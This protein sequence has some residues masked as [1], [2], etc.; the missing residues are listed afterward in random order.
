MEINY[1]VVIRTIGKA[2][3]KYQ[4]LLDSIDALEPKPQ[5]VIVVLPEGYE[6]PKEQLGYERFCFSKKGMIYQRVY[7]LEQCKTPYA[8]FCDD[9]V[10]FPPDF[11]QKLFRPIGQGL[12]GLSAGPLLSFLPDKGF[13]S[14][15]SAILGSAVPTVF[16]KDMYVKLL[17]TGGWAFNR[18][19]DT[20]NEHYYLTES[21]AGTCFFADTNR[22]RSVDF[23]DEIWVEKMGY[24]YPEDQ[25]M[26]CKA[27]LRNIKTMVVSDA[28]YVHADAKTST[29]GINLK[30]AYASSFNKEVYWHRFVWEQQRGIAAKTWTAICRGYVICVSA[31]YRIVRTLVGRNDWE[32]YKAVSKGKRDGRKYIKSAEY[33]NLPAVR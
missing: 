18:N 33:Q 30:A 24:A 21:V 11:V 10:N 4:A 26:F 32:Y 2:G 13:K 23:F 7:G 19:V 17:R 16:H 25:V 12:C 29:A 28:L 14:F 15:V 3:E 8:L 27:L 6:L 31:V 1:S 5:E 22:F 9:D 20:E